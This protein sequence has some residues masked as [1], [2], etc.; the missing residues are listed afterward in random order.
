MKIKDLDL[1]AIFGKNL[2]MRRIC[3]TFLV[4]TVLCFIRSIWLSHG[5]IVFSDLDFGMDDSTYIARIAGLYNQQFS[6]MNFFNL[7]R[8]VFILPFYLLSLAG[9]K[10]VCHFLLKSIITG[11]FILSAAGMYLL[12]ERILQRNF[13]GFTRNYHYVGLIIP[14]L[15]YAVNPWV[16]M[17]IQHLFLLAGYAA[18]PWVLL[19]FMEFMFAGE[20][21]KNSGIKELNVLGKTVRLKWVDYAEVK[22]AIL[23]AVFVSIGSAGIHYFLY[24]ILTFIFFGLMILSRD[25]QQSIKEKSGFRNTL[26]AHLRKAVFLYG[27]C[28]AFNA[29]WL[30]T[31]LAAI[32][33]TDIQP[34]NVNVVETLNIFSRYSTLPRVLYLISYWWPMFNLDNYLDRYFWISGGVL[35]GIIAYIVFYRYSWRFYIRLYANAA[36]FALLLAMGTNTDIIGDLN[37][38]I[39]TKLPVIGHIFRDP[40]KIIG[41]LVA[42]LAILIGFGVDRIIYFLKMANYNRAVQLLFVCSLLVCLHMY[43]RPF[44][45]VFINGYYAGAEAPQDYREVQEHYLPGGKIFW[46]PNMDN[47]LLSNGMTNYN[48]N[49]ANGIMKTAGDFHLYSSAKP[50]VFQ[51]ENNYVLINYIQSYFQYLLDTA[52]AQNLGLLAGWMGFNEVGFHRDVYG[53][54]ERTAFNRQVLEGQKDLAKHYQD[55]TFSLYA[56]PDDQGKILGINRLVYFTKGLNS[57]LQMFDR[58]EDLKVSPE[59]TGLVWA[60]SRQQDLRFEPGDIMVGDNKWDFIMPLIDKRYFT[61]PFDYINTGN[62]DTAWAKTMVKESEWLWLLKLNHITDKNWDYDY[63]RGVVYTTTPYELG[64]SPHK[65]P[66]Y[67]GQQILGMKDVLSRQFFTPENPDVFNL[68]VFPETSSEGV[69]SGTIMGGVSGSNEWQVASSQPVRIEGGKFIRLY[70]LVS[71]INTGKLHFKVYFYDDYH[72]EIKVSYAT[73]AGEMSEYTRVPVVCDTNVPEGTSFMEI[74][75]LSTQDV[76]KPVYFWIHDFAVYDNSALKR[77]NILS[78]PVKSLSPD[79]RYRVMARVFKSAAGGRL[80]IKGEDRSVEVDLKDAKNRFEWVEAGELALPRGRLDIAPGDGFSVINVLLVIPA[81][82]FERIVCEA[83]D[84]LNGAQADVSLLLNDYDIQDEF[85]VKDL[86]ETRRTPGS[87]DDTLF[88]ICKGVASKKIDIL[89]DGYYSFYVTGNIPGGGKAG[90]VIVD[91][92][93]NE[94]MLSLGDGK[95]VARSLMD[96]RCGVNHQKNSYFLTLEPDRDENWKV[97]Q[98]YGGKI[99]LTRGAYQIRLDIDS[100]DRNNLQPDTLHPLSGN[101]ITVPAENNDLEDQY[102]MLADLAGSSTNITREKRGNRNIFFNT[103]YRGRMWLIYTLDRAPVHKGQLI[104]FKAGLSH[105]ALKDVHAK[106]LWV[107]NDGV[108]QKSQFV[109]KSS[110][111]N[112]YYLLTRAPIDGYVQACFFA[113][114]DGTDKGV[115]SLDDAELIDVDESVKIEGTFLLPENIPE[116]L[117]GTAKERLHGTASIFER[118]GARCVVYNEP[119]NS[120]WQMYGGGKTGKNPFPVNLIHNGY[121]AG[122]PTSIGV[123]MI[124]PVLLSAYGLGVMITLFAFLSGFYILYRIPRSKNKN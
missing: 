91:G 40:N 35:L 13:G 38:L 123:I 52:G 114:S 95:A 14:A 31:Y 73:I 42:Y 120:V 22:A 2:P 54:E 105:D 109:S 62:P 101:E 33:I 30:F 12:C 6:S 119:F 5:Y 80:V 10:V 29:Y 44:Q 37:V 93:G 97:K 103:P 90:A 16:I 88:P 9:G 113:H 76:A 36:V 65:A 111:S 108:L 79:G 58:R 115:F 45:A 26:K 112:N 15:Y 25:L 7:S 75:I 49:Q 53:Q 100:H 8:L 116:V 27:T 1:Y 117:A 11:I 17:R 3:I 124:N 106:L 85:P 50:A 84:R 43:N 67:R 59:D 24:Y 57:L 110:F 21:A 66:L 81:G 46:A 77:E 32:F 98:Y 47:M 34:Q 20:I 107:S 48:W 23:V 41:P 122:G 64:I 69:L 60:Q 118:D 51:N 4:A 72:N 19:Y 28:L 87:I 82:E 70:S 89:K 96:Y 121:T 94:R 74:H 71:G 99:Y 56:T 55:S 102:L 68:T 18:Y 63:G 86:F 92:D 83:S 104:S 78:V 39:V 61:Y